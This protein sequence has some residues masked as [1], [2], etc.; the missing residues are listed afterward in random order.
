M[1]ITCFRVNYIFWVHITLFKGIITCF[2][3][4]VKFSQIWE[5]ITNNF[6]NWLLELIIIDKHTV[7]I[8]N[9]ID[10]DENIVTFVYILSFFVMGE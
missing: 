7:G 4:L 8:L 6:E 9:N 2:A 5:I 3:F 1:Y 10:I